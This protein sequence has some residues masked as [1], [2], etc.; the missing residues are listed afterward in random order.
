MRPAAILLLLAASARADRAEVQAA[1]DAARDEERREEAL[2]RVLTVDADPAPLKLSGERR[3][4]FAFGPRLAAAGGA[5][6]LDG[7][8]EP[9]LATVTPETAGA[10]LKA[11]EQGR[12]VARVSF[13]LAEAE[14]GAG[15]TIDRP[16]TAVGGGRFLHVRAAP[17]AVEL[18]VDGKS[19]ARA[20]TPRAA[21]GAPSV[22]METPTVA[23]AAGRD[24]YLVAQAALPLKDGA[25]ACYQKLPRPPPTG[26]LALQIAV[27]PSGAVDEEAPLLDSLRDDLLWS[28]VAAAAKALEFP[29][30]KKGA[31]VTTIL[32][33]SLKR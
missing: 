20:T 28:C 21:E 33:F 4:S 14:A 3:V 15:P 31:R 22:E 11:R 30:T 16:C 13:R 7:G 27:A 9:A 18:L 12:L 29:R 2:A 17:L 10:L 5:L 26:A 1:C 24:A 19:L 32:K 8:D 6:T 23:V 25:L